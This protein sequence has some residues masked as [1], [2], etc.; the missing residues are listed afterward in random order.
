MNTVNKFD[1]V[2]F[3]L[4]GIFCCVMGILNKNVSLFRFFGG[5]LKRKRSLEWVRFW[6]IVSGILLIGLGLG[7]FFK[8]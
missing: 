2:F 4:A 1:F 3:L 8:K 5:D 7:L 6:N